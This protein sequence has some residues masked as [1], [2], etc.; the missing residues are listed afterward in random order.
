MSLEYEPF[1]GQMDAPPYHATQA[2]LTAEAVPEGPEAE[3]LF[4][5]LHGS[6]GVYIASSNRSP[7]TDSSVPEATH[8]P[9]VT[10]TNFWTHRY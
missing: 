8:P 9:D 4:G 10:G 3:L 7:M 1:S 2:G 6:T 5:A